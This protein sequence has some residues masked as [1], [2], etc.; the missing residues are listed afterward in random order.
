LPST[1]GVVAVV[2]TAAAFAERVA[3]AAGVDDLGGAEGGAIVL[4]GGPARFVVPPL[5]PRVVVADHPCLAADV[6][7][8]EPDLEPVVGAVEANPQ[9]ATA[10]AVLLRGASR[11]STAEGLLAESAVYGVLQGGA[12]FA[13]WRAGRP[14]REREP[15]PG[16]VVGVALVDDVLEIE[17]R[18]P[19]VRNAVD[20]RLRD[21]LASALLL[22]A[23]EPARRVVLRGA[24]PTFCSGGDLDEFGS[25]DDPASAH[26]VRLSRHLGQLVDQLRDR[27]TVHVHG[28]CAGS[29][30]ELAAFAECVIAHPDTTFALPEISLGLIPGAGGTVSVPRRIGRQR[31]ALLAL[32]GRPIDAV[33]ALGWGLVDRIERIEHR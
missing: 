22:A 21:E 27:L 3:T 26:L 5:L 18:R 23:A 31:T 29:G 20:V 19:D 17:L 12:E 24:G 25:R 9:A 15:S 13:S 7:A 33:T 11:R 2:L 10:L 32:G 8:E 16:P 14:A 6:V 4:T 28:A 30:V 1:V